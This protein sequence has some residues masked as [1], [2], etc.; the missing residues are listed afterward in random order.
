MKNTILASAFFLLIGSP[1][2]AAT[3]VECMAMWKQA[4]VNTD[5]KLTSDEAV[6]Y[7]AMM[8]VAEKPVPADDVITEAMF[9]ENCLDSIFDT[10][11]MDVGAPFEGANSFT[12]SQAQDRLL[13][14][15]MTAPS[16]LIKDDRGIWRG[17]ATE[18]GQPVSV[19][20]D[21]K[22]NVVAE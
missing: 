11:E 4:D 22:G 21:F 1:A 2:L 20:V 18:N 12:E 10:A 8:R 15:G 9:T 6:R 3:D 16:A 13:A 7:F 14:A 19:S 17:T 5:G